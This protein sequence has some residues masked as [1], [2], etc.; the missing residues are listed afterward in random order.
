MSRKSKVSILTMRT[1][2]PH[3]YFVVGRSGSKHGLPVS[4]ISDSFFTH[5]KAISILRYESQLSIGLFNK[6]MTLKIEFK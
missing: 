1:R 5:R 3:I 2:R 6:H 4:V